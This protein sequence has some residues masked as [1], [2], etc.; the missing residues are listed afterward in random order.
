MHV[1]DAPETRFG[2]VWSTLGEYSLPPTR[3]G[4]EACA[5]TSGARVVSARPMATRIAQAAWLEGLF[6]FT[7]VS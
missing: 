3:F 2:N 1:G 5:M 4:T 7:D 6:R